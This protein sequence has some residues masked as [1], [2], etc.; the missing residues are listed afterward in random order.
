MVNF[1][2]DN[3]AGAS[4][5]IVAALAAAA[6]GPALP[7]GEDDWTRRVE[8]RLAE[9][10]ETE[11]AAF[12]VATGTTANALAL[13]VMVPPFGAVY[14]HKEAHV[15]VDE[16][17][18]PEF[19]TGGA[20]LVP[21]KGAHGKIA[22][23]DLAAATGGA[24]VV[25]HVQ[26][27]AVSL[28]QSTEAGTLYTPD[29]LHAIAEVARARGLGL[30]VDGARFAN[31]LVS[32]GRSP[33]EITWKA[34]VEALSFG[35]TKNGAL[36]A[37]AVILFKPGLGETFGYRRKRGG[38]LFSKMRFLSVQLE[39][40]LEGDLWLNNARHANAMAGRLAEGLAELPGVRLSHPVQANEIFARL[41]EAMIAGLLD[42]GFRFYRWGPEENSEVRL[43]A[44]F[45]TRPE[46][47][48]AFL[49][50]ARAL[51]GAGRRRA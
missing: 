23:E 35:A 39:A 10:F 13:S 25:H 8:A 1:C 30:H 50:A 20:K 27:A 37:E 36:A 2:S 18:A 51:A 14:C 15:N 11:L 49:A 32:L 5:E 3:A 17:G 29:E 26:P 44:S 16:C 7:Y 31:A 21:L 48:E 43:V 22:A 24:G 9:I 19:F 41:P 34:G 4:P 28:S 46:D 33:A 12:P 42:K 38:H 6:H 40:Y 45:D 47:V